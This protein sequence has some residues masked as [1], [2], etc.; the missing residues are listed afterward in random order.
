MKWLIAAQIRQTQNGWIEHIIVKVN[1]VQ[2]VQVRP[3]KHCMIPAHAA[4]VWGCGIESTHVELIKWISH[5]LSTGADWIMPM[6]LQL[7]N[8]PRQMKCFDLLSY[9]VSVRTRSAL[10]TIYF[11]ILMSFT[12]QIKWT[13]ACQ[14]KLRMKWSIAAQIRQIHK[15]MIT[16]SPNSQ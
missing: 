8:H 12:D 7:W 9:A 6:L 2:T 15:K 14:L 1:Q 11:V 4:W 3:T 13:K 16:W 5:L 10:Q